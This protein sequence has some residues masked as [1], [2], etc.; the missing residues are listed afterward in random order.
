MYSIK[1]FILFISL[2]FLNMNIGFAQFEIQG[3]RGCRGLMPENTIPAFLRAIDEGVETLE[4]DVIISKDNK[5]VVS[6]EPQF[7]PE[8]TTKPDGSFFVKM[9]DSNLHKL[10]YNEI[11]RYDVGLKGHSGYP[12]QQKMAVYKPLLTD[13]IKAVNAHLKTKGRSEIKYNIEIKSLVEEYG[14]SQ[15][16]P[17]EFCD[18]VLKTIGKK[19]KPENLTIQS[20]DF[21]VLKYLNECALKSKTKP[22]DISVLLEPMENNEITYNIDKLGF[23]PDIWSPYFKVL[24]PEMV[25][26]LKEKHIK[27]IP[28]TVNTLDDMRKVKEMGC[29][30]L[31]TDYP[32]RAKS[33]N[34]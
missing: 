1:T 20:F 24:K 19:I 11:K 9:Q 18:L 17:K 4:L 3:H 21:N 2:S 13:V 26:E 29:D 16:K 28:W 31:I 5:V 30:G 14:I 15:P 12:E 33:I 6:H 32:N 10:T 27:V 25:N 23:K 22:F 7:N 34:L 8:I